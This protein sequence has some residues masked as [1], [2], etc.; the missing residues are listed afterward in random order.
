MTSATTSYLVCATQRSGSTLLCESLKS[1][2]VAGCPEEFF[3][4][5]VR[6]GRPRTAAGYF[7]EPGAPDIGEILGD[8]EKLGPAPDY[9][10]LDGIGDYA[11]HLERSFKTGTT[12][13]G[14]FGAKLMWGHLDDFTHFATRLPAFRNLELEELLPAVFPKPRY[15]WVT[16]RDKVRQA[17]SLWKAIQTE[18]W[19]GDD[20]P[21]DHEPQYHEE[22]VDHL[23][24]MLADHD[25][26]WE[27][28]W[29]RTGIEPLVISYE[30]DLSDA[31]P[32]RAVRKVLRHLDLSVPPGWHAPEHM[33]RQADERSNRWVAQYRERATPTAAPTR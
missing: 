30:D 23:V 4:A 21:A 9:S 10:S 32:E 19:R 27:A 33:S 15:V 16:R 8:P 22:A 12:A 29:A 5:R 1:T 2:G 17:V 6:T 7:R 3:E 18:A 26:H 25:T 28:F 14:V 11:E 20:N 13:N 31:G 24:K